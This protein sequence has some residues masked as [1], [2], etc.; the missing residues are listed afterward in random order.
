MSELEDGIR[1]LL[2]FA[3][4][5]CDVSIQLDEL[6][7]VRDKI[8]AAQAELER[9]G[10]EQE[11]VKAETE[12]ARGESLQMQSN[13]RDHEK[14]I[15]ALQDRHHAVRQQ[16]AKDLQAETERLI[17]GRTIQ[18]KDLDDQ[19]AAK[20]VIHGDLWGKVREAR[21]ELDRTKTELN[22]FVQRFK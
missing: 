9:L 5:I 17:A 3:T 10:K 4:A 1:G 21:E 8:V 20:Q 15:V 6:E 11:I 2:P 7:K 18:L 14:A 12:K 22:D 13:V 16:N 19:I